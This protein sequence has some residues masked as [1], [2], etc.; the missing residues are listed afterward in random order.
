MAIE[1]IASLGTRGVITGL[2][3]DI[4]LRIVVQALVTDGIAVADGVRVTFGAGE[5]VK[6]A[7][8]LRMIGTQGRVIPDVAV[9]GIAA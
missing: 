3:T 7:D 2:Q 9:T 4:G 6:T 8:M 5:I 1:V